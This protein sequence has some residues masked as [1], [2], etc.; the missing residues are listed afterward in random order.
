MK[1]TYKSDSVYNFGTRPSVDNRRATIRFSLNWKEKVKCWFATH[2]PWSEYNMYKRMALHMET[3]L[4]D[5]YNTI[6]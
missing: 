5:H 3:K 2:W 1:H 4:K 6:K